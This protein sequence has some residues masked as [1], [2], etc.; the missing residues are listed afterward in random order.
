MKNSNTALWPGRPY[1][2]G[3]TWDGEGVNF[4]LFSHHAEQV[5]LCLFD[6]SGRHEIKQI[7]LRERTGPIWHG[8]WP[9]ARPGL[10]Y[11]Y[12]VKGPYQPEQGQ[13]FNAHKLLLDPYAKAIV[14]QIQWS[15]AQFGYRIGGR[16]EDL[17]FNSRNSAS[18]MPRCQVVDNSFFWGDDRPPRTPWHDTVLYELHVRGFTQR[19]RE[20]PE[21]LRGTYA[22]LAS[23]PVI[24][25]LKA[26]GITAVELLP[27][28]YFVDE[29][30]LLRSTRTIIVSVR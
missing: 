13:R 27:V 11:G 15:D 29:R 6:P 30:Q 2:L 24:D 18:G 28:Q 20:V 8:Y 9:D 25:Y 10:L 12:R 4:A 26:L 5:M 3:A 21:P 1:P 19:H 17:S 16:A 22:G 14:G 23:G 7:A